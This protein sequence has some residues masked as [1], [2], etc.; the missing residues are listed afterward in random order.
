MGL[1]HQHQR[2]LANLDDIDVVQGGS[3]QSS[4]TASSNLNDQQLE[5]VDNGEE[6][7]VDHETYRTVVRNATNPYTLEVTHSLGGR[8]TTG[9]QLDGSQ[10]TW[11]RFKAALCKKLMELDENSVGTANPVRFP[12]LGWNFRGGVGEILPR[13]QQVTPPK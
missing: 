9:R 3:P 10:G 12:I 4:L 5:V 1:H 7:V 8:L 11:E 13:T 6:G 2:M